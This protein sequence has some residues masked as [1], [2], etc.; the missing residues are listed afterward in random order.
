MPIITLA[1]EGISP[2]NNNVAE[3]SAVASPVINRI[4]LIVLGV[5]LRILLD[6]YEIYNV[7]VGLIIAP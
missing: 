2:R 3:V 7:F 4:K 5:S 6:D 1:D